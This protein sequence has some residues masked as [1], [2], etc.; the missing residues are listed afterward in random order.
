MGLAGLFT[1]Q[2]GVDRYRFDG[3]LVLGAESFVAD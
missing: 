2:M 1:G 3:E